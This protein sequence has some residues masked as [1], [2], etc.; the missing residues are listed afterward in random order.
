V[1]TPKFTVT[2]P[3]YNEGDR[4]ARCLAGWVAQR[5]NDLD[6]E[7]IVVD[8]GSDTDPRPLYEAVGVT[9]IRRAGLGHPRAAASARNIGIFAARGEWIITC[10]ADCIPAP[11]YLQRAADILRA[12]DGALFLTGERVFVAASEVDCSALA[13]GT[14]D[15]ASLPRVPS[16]SNYGYARDLRSSFAVG[17]PDV[18]HPWTYMHS[19]NTVFPRAAACAVGGYDESYDGN[20]GHEDIDFAYRL[21]TAAGASPRWVPGLEVYHQEP[22]DPPADATQRW[23]RTHNPNWLRLC[24]TVPGYAEFKREQYRALGLDVLDPTS[25]EAV[26]SDT[27]TGPA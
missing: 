25:R 18:P 10:D 14:F 27:T 24:A 12:E 23:D 15:L 17:L 9:V 7:V 5:G 8:N 6:L 26:V 19:C 4:L 1:S 13:A 11:G 22:T 2:I 16:D 20:W 3:T 21:I